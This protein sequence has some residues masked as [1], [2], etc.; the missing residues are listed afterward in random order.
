MTLRFI[1]LGV[2]DAFSALYYSSSLLVIAT[3]DSRE[4]RL[5]I[6][7]P[8]PLRK[9][10]REATTATG[11]DLSIETIHTALLTHLHGDHV[12]G[13]ECFGFYKRFVEGSRPLLA[14]AEPVL[15]ELW[16][17]RLCAAMRQLKTPNGTTHALALDDYFD[18]QTLTQAAS[19]RI[20]PFH[21]EIRPTLHHIPCFALRITASGRT[22]AYSCDTAFDPGLIEW[23]EAGSDLIVHE[24]NLG[25]H[26]PY[27]SLVALPE[28]IRQ[29]M[30]LIHYHDQFDAE[31][32]AIECL[33]QGRI[34]DV[35]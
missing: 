19:N 20:G 30:R 33:R 18:I 15:A 25:M 8:D 34:Y 3:E 11:L 7:F 29:R 23:L 1:P 35:R 2:G 6:D 22:L 14:V 32:S 26:T 9:V 5:L 12:N 27:E 4:H 13:L 10:L 17:G 28:K 31:R 21:I 24:T 16:D